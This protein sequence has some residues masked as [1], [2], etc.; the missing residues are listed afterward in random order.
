MSLIRYRNPSVL[1]DFRREMNQLFN[2]D[3]PSR[4]KDSEQ[5]SQGDWLPAV[6][7]KEEDQR[8]LVVADVPGFK[9]EEIDVSIDDNGRLVV[10]GE[11][12]KETRD[13]KDNYLRVERRSGSFYR[14]F[15]LP[16]NIDVDGITAKV[17]HGLMEVSIP[18]ST[19]SAGR[20]IN[21]EG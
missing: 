21:V 19:K 8:F 2:S 15:Y 1:D 4:D 16:D 5:L 9:P 20:Q 6:D 7:I 10:K 11:Q 13:E 18:K 12:K 3:Y 14:A 17:N